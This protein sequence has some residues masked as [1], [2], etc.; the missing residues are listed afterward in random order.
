MSNR[1]LRYRS[2]ATAA[3][4]RASRLSRHPAMAEVLHYLRRSWFTRRLSPGT[5][6]ARLRELVRLRLGT[7]LRA[8]G[9]LREPSR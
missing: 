8:F 7:P 4:R 3:A 9:W 6:R 5:R 2:S 1:S